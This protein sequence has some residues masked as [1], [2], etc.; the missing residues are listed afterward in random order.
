M[1]KIAVDIAKS[2]IR[3][4]KLKKDSLELLLTKNFSTDK[5]L[6]EIKKELYDFARDLKRKSP[7]C[8]IQIYT[9]FLNKQVCFLRNKKVDKKAWASFVNE[10][11]LTTGIC[12]CLTNREIDST[13]L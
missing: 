10:F 9:N 12:I 8:T 7:R 1:N 5:S 6:L 11:Y 3:V 2:E 4:F 13:A